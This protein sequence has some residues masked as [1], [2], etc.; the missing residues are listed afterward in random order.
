M[1]TDEPAPAHVQVQPPDVLPR[2]LRW[3]TIFAIGLVVL[4]QAPVPL[5]AQ[6][7]RTRV[8]VEPYL[9][10][11]R[12]GG[13][14]APEENRWGAVAGARVAVPI[15][16]RLR[17]TASITYTN[18]ARALRITGDAGGFVYDE[19][20]VAA[21]G[22]AEY[23]ILITPATRLTLGAEVGPGWSRYSESSR[24][25]SPRPALG[26]ADQSF[27]MGLVGSLDASVWR[28]LSRSTAVGLMLRNFAG[29]G[30]S[31]PTVSPVLA[32]GFALR[33]GNF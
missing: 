2:V 1:R 27:S 7:S 30:N 22:G 13:A 12:L 24:F 29:L 17:I 4:V 5:T 33:P 15:A 23:D 8:I 31:S 25:G 16:S 9:G 28:S 6:Q 18:V 11:L 26:L 20:G 3:P 19:T 10:T 32:L 14:R 21:M